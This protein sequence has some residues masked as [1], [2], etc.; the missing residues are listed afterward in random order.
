MK[1]QHSQG[2]EEFSRQLHA[3]FETSMG[4]LTMVVMA[5]TGLLGVVMF[6]VVSVKDFREAAMRAH[7]EQAILR[8][9]GLNSK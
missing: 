2:A 9:L 1:K 8:W 6:L 4:K 3:A 7:Q 5:I